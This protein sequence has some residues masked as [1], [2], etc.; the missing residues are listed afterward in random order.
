M[1]EARGPN[2]SLYDAN[3]KGGFYM[4]EP[5]VTNRLAYVDQSGI[6]SIVAV[7]DPVIS[8]KGYMHWVPAKRAPTCPKGAPGSDNVATVAGPAHI[9]T[10][11][12]DTPSLADKAVE[13]LRDTVASLW[14]GARSSRIAQWL[15][16]VVTSLLDHDKHLDLAQWARGDGQTAALPVP[17]MQ[18]C[19]TQQPLTALAHPQV[20]ATAV[21]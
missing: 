11:A 19:S 3:G 18:I 20:L 17:S 14:Q 2:G 9:A 15:Q 12:A 8:S 10:V 6:D 21:P 1:C 7:G 13:W 4:P 5:V 16:E